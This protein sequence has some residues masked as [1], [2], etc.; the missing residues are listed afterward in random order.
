M[1]LIP[2]ELKIKFNFSTI[3]NKKKKKK[4]EKKIEIA[5]YDRKKQQH[6]YFL[7]LFTLKTV[8]EKQ[9]NTL[10]ISLIHSLYD[11]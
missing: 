9:M 6:R 2:T 1:M 11:T 7:K 10:P 8:M 5:F 3:H 4:E